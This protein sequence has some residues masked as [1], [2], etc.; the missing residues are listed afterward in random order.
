MQTLMWKR[1]RHLN[2]RVP[3]HNQ[4]TAESFDNSAQML[5]DDYAKLNKQK[6]LDLIV[7][8]NIRIRRRR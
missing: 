5:G 8:M 6:V 3:K 2:G 1:L 4:F 7:W